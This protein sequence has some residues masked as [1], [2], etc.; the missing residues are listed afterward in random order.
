MPIQYYMRGYNT[1]APG[2]VGYVDWVVN[3]APDAAATFV[4]APFLTANI[5]NVVVNRIVES[6][7]E[8]FLNPVEST[9]SIGLPDPGIGNFI[10]INAYD[11]LHPSSPPGTP[12]PPTFPVGIAGLAVVRGTPDGT[13]SNPNPYASLFWQENIQQWT[14]AFA[15]DTFASI[16]ALLPV[17]MGAL[18]MSSPLTIGTPAANTG[19]IRLTNAA[20]I[21]SRDV[22]NFPPGITG[23][24]L[25]IGSDTSNRVILGDANKAAG[26]I[27]DVITGSEY[28]Y[29][30]NGVP[31]IHMGDSFITI[32]TLVPTTISQSTL[33]VGVGGSGQPLTLLAQNTTGT[34]TTGGALNLS[35]GSGTSVAG[36]VNLQTGSITRA[37]VSPTAITQETSTYAFGGTADLVNVTNPT[38]KQNDNTTASTVGQTLTI[39]SQNSTGATAIGGALVLSSGS[40]TGTPVINQQSVFVQTGGTNQIIVS[41][42]N[43]PAMS[44]ATTTGKV[45]ITGNLEVQGTTTT[46]DSTVVYIIGR[47]LHANWAD[48]SVSP[49]V[50]VP[51]QITGYSIH[52]GN[53]SGI[54]RDG[55]A[56]IWVEGSLNSGADGYWKAL[57]TVGDGYGADGYSAS[58]ALNNLGVQANNFSFSSDP[59]PVTGTLPGTGGLRA[60][61]NTTAVSSRNTSIITTLTATGLSTS[62][63]AT[64]LSSLT[65]LNVTSTTGFS[66][67][68]GSLFVAT[69]TGPQFAT[70]TGTSG[71]SF[72]GFVSS[73]TGRVLAGNPVA[74]T[75]QTTTIAA[76]SN[77]QSLPQTTINVASNVGFPTSGTLRIVTT[78]GVQNVTYTNISGTTQFTG[79]SGGTGTM[80]TGNSVSGTPI[81]GTA[82]H[83]LVG[84][85]PFNHI[86][87]GNSFSPTNSGFIFGTTTG[88]IADF[89][90]NGVSQIQLGAQDVESDGYAETVTIGPFVASPRIYQIA[91]PLTGANAGTNMMLQAQAGQNVA[92]G[93]N[94]NGGGLTLASG[95]AGT[96]GTNGVAGMVAI[97][98]GAVSTV[99]FNSIDTEA[100][101]YAELMAIGSTITNPR[102]YQ[103]ATAG[104]TGSNLLLEAQ[105]GATNGGALS[106]SSG[107]GS[108]A[109]NAGNVNIQTGL[110]TRVVVT[111]SFTTFQ[112]TAEAL[113]I[114]PVSAGTTQITYASTVTAAQIN[115]TATSSTPSAPMTVQSQVTT[116]A[117]GVGG[118]LSLIA[119]NATGTTSTGGALNLASGSGTTINGVINFQPGGTTQLTLSAT[120]STLQWVSTVTSPTLN[121]ATT[122]GASGQTLTIQ[123]QNALTTGGNVVVTSGTGV[124]AGNVNLQTGGVTRV[125]VNPTFTTFNDTSEAY[126]ITPVSAGAT[127][128][129]AINTATSVTYKQGDLTTNGGVGAA[130]TLQAQ[131]ETGTTSTGGA[132]NLTSGTGTTTAGNVNIQTGG[133]T[134]MSINP[135]FVTYSDTAEA[136]R[137]TPVSAGTTSLQFATTV[138]LAKIFQADLTTNNVTAAPMTIQA[139]NET[140]TTSAGGAL[141][142]T[143][144]TGTTTNGAVNL[145][146]GGTTT[147]SLVT[148]K[149]VFNKGRRRN[150]TAVST[151]YLVLASDDYVAVTA[152]SV[153]TITLPA[154]PATGD[155]YEFK[156]ING[157][158]G[159]NAVTISGNGNNIDGAA[160]VTLNA[161]YAELIV[162]FTGAQW[163]V[164]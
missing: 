57:T 83:I 1:T 87:M 90:V 3:D 58:N 104:A 137:V 14:F 125:S 48:P 39:R 42:I 152:S 155:T 84:T 150:V 141:N 100:D 60:P 103:I 129:Q 148:N 28:Q 43:L 4:P 50:A 130:T 118:T 143:S 12:I 101:G 142:L 106:L 159:T 59:N 67:P 121:Q 31:K 22:A 88:S 55:A 54:P 111:P 163:S 109:A 68:A 74:Q 157:T 161:N 151:T 5:V 46:V 149:F 146:V 29:Q 34:T 19:D 32:D 105:N 113:R 61:H 93:T 6:R 40:S 153:Y 92:A 64:L 13:L 47:V 78:G 110:L 124:T 119:G 30:I 97:N 138:T 66:S 15:N 123:A 77:N 73:G 62:A 33:A 37:I 139:Q 116:A 145:Q 98:I 91:Q 44:Y 76:G 102:I 36:N 17:N 81:P 72:T 27:F 160:S 8:N 115:Q 156:D 35:S 69:D 11:F 16:G 41:P 131:N 26:F 112:D 2:A 65:T 70:Y 120:G 164:S 133:S 117:S 136:Y 147:A 86:I 56:W 23:D 51:S 63:P 135:T 49:N 162:T 99:T 79:A 158:S 126:R 18:T 20:T 144:G 82:D 53:A 80:F 85:D 21:K 94:N 122:G 95:P 25:L 107:T 154:A 7:V 128:L 52:R 24:I 140:G 75:H 9:G 38:I 127:T 96:G 89:W 45:I 71:T 108:S 114:T 134:R 132:L 10:H